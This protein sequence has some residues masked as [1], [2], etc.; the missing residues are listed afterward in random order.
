[1]ARKK[2]VARFCRTHR[3]YGKVK[4]LIAALFSSVIELDAK[5]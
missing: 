3:K 2:S 4:A 5:Q 1:M